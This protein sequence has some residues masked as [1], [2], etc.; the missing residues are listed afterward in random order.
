MTSRVLV[1]VRCDNCGKENEI[2]YQG[3]LKCI[4]DDGKYYCLQCASRLFNSGENSYRWNPNLS[5]EQREANNSRVGNVNG[6]YEFIRIVQH[7]DSYKCVICGS[8]KKSMYII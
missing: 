8:K 1:Q 7:R 2:I 3:Y 6:Y 5:E 4:R